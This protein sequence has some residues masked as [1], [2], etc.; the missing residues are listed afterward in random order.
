M[1]KKKKAVLGNKLEIV[2]FLL[3]Q[4]VPPTEKD[5]DGITPLHLAAHNGNQEIGKFFFIHI[6][7]I[8][9]IVFPQ[10]NQ[11]NPVKALLEANAECNSFDNEQMIPLHHAVIAGS[12]EVV[13]CLL[14]KGSKVNTQNR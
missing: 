14:K 4:T 12:V 3:S 2:K 8:D 5:N 9:S 11:S 1:K 13:D 10:M 6:F 7:S